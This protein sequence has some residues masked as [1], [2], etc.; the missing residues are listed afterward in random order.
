M[1]GWGVFE[2]YR[3]FD[4]DN[5]S[6][7]L[8]AKQQ[9]L[10]TTMRQAQ[11]PRLLAPKS[12]AGNQSLSGSSTQNH[13]QPPKTNFQNGGNAVEARNSQ[14]Q[15]RQSKQSKQSKQSNPNPTQPNQGAGRK[16]PQHKN[17]QKPLG[18]LQGIL[19]SALYDSDSKKL[20]G[21]LAAEDLLL[22]A[23]IFLL[24]E[25]DGE[26]NLL[27]IIALAYVLISDYIELPEFG[28]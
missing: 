6:T 13:G 8:T 19:P 1:L 20:F 9:Q 11:Q 21:F 15:S 12:G 27:M 4:N 18:F 23:L 14:A 7:N 24:L 26:D 5:G 22:V 2:I 16:A 3:R 28:F 25:K 17:A 10:P